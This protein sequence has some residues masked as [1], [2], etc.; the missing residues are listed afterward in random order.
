[1]LPFLFLTRGRAWNRKTILF[2]LLAVFTVLFIDRFT[3]ILELLLKETQYENVVSEWKGFEDDGTNLLR[4][5]V[6]AVPTLLSLFGLRMIRAAND[7]LIDLCVNMSIVSTGIYLVSA[8][9]SGIF[10]GR[11]PIYFSLYNYILLPWEL[12]HLFTQRSARTM[13][14]IMVVFYVLFYFYGLKTFGLL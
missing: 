7:P 13:T 12:H 5:S 6:Y 8:F 11:L 10:I 1:M 3:N 9:T 4:V 2:V 14:V